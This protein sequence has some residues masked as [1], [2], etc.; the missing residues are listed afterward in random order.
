MA[1]V[2][3]IIAAFVVA[4]LAGQADAMRKFVQRMQPP[5]GDDEENATLL[6]A[7]AP[8]AALLEEASSS[9]TAA[10]APE[11]AQAEKVAEADVALLNSEDAAVDAVSADADSDSVGP[12][13][14]EED[15]SQTA[16][17]D[18]EDGF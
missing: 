18:D 17:H 2:R 10:I 14:G 12:K 7:Q 15:D 6:S 13:E 9:V 3:A 1:L 11:V 5:P 16:S 8:D 4:S